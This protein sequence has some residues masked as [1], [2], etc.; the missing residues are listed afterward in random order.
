VRERLRGGVSAP[1]AARELIA[2]ALGEVAGE[3]TLRDLMLLAT[4][5]VT[6]AVR[7]AHVSDGGTIELTAVARGGRVRVAVS[8]PGATTTPRMQE[9]DVD[10]PGGMGLYLVDQISDRWGVDGGDGGAT[11]VWF[12]LRL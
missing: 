1:A 8:D 6:N 3:E 12:E 4:E 2:Q 5:L 10:V 7:H 11:R 9:L